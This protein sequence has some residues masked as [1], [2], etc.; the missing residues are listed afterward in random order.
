[1]RGK[2]AGTFIAFDAES[3]EK[4]DKFVKG[5]RDRGVIIGGSGDKAVRL[6]PMLCV[7]W[8]FFLLTPDY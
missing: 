3:T 7:S 4:R 5:M 2:D 6:R 8:G 1:L